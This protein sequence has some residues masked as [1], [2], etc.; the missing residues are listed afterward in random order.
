L[1]PV[2]NS[3]VP[4]VVGGAIG[5][6]ALVA[7]IV[8]GFFGSS[9]PAFNPAEYLTWIYFW[10]AMV[11]LSG[12]VGNLWALFNPFAAIYSVLARV[13]PAREPLPL[14]ARIGV[15]PAAFFYFAFVCLELTS[16]MANRPWF[17]ALLAV[18]YTL[19]NVAGMYTYGAEAWLKHFEAFTVLLGIVGRFSPV[20]V[21]D[22][23]GR[24]EVSLRPWGVGLLR[25]DGG[26]WDL[27]LFVILML[28]SLAFD[29]ILATPTWQDFNTALEP[30]WLPLGAFGFFLVRTTGFVLLTLI[31]IAAF[32]FFM[33]LVIQF[34][35][36]RVDRTATMTAFVFTLVPIALVYNAA[37][38]YSYVFVQ[39]QGLIPLLADPLQRGWHLLPTQGY[40]VSFALAGAAT[41]W[42]AQVILI[43]LGHII[44]VFLAHLRAGERF[45]SARRALMSQYP[46][47]A[48][49]VAYT[50][51]SLWILAQPITK[52][53]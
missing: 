27:I 20:E 18:F 37:H 21:A 34:S 2:F 6:L 50:M 39:S 25:I 32:T 41:V 24:K 4:R 30:I 23:D 17:V 14:P 1:D 29:G 36:S 42:Y 51:T 49:M 46:M 52:G 26:G 35:R 7:I 13:L 11:I 15:W 22:S 12:L 45:R 10:A 3:H 38:N 40:Q 47:L 31:F 28:S 9:Q 19:W 48:L 5:V 16:G 44:A 8:C 33:Q 43:V 53:G